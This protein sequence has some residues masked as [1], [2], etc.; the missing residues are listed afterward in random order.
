MT[1]FV[2][3]YTPT[4]EGRIRYILTRLSESRPFR[5]VRFRY[6]WRKSRGRAWHACGLLFLN[7]WDHF[8]KMLK[9]SKFPLRSLCDIW[10][11]ALTGC[12]LQPWP[13]PKTKTFLSK[14]YLTVDN[15]HHLNLIIFL[16][17]CEKILLIF[18]FGL[19]YY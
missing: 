18:Y 16:F 5:F 4:N 11:Q 19:F 13:R 1:G 2:S 15:W 7:I 17:I 8:S 10:R 9:F 6:T 14:H 12:K 3:L